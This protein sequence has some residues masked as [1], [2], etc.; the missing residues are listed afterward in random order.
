MLL[1]FVVCRIRFTLCN[2]F[3]WGVVSFGCNWYAFDSHYILPFWAVDGVSQFDMPSGLLVLMF[4][5]WW[6][7]F[8]DA[9]SSRRNWYALS[10]YCMFS[11][12]L[13]LLS[14]FVVFWFQ[15]CTWGTC[16]LP[17]VMFGFRFVLEVLVFFR[18]W[19]VCV[20]DGCSSRQKRPLNAIPRLWMFIC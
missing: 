17:W 18:G 11:V 3:L 19:C 16:L 1:T 15:I 8:S 6:I 10:L 4:E 2:K 13:S 9:V 14:S 12:F 5:G 7:L 20:F